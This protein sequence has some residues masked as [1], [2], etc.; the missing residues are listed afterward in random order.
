[1]IPLPLL[2]V[3]VPMAIFA[4]VGFIGYQTGLAQMKKNWDA[5]KQRIELAQAREYLR[6]SEA[7]YG[8][9][10]R[11][12]TREKQAQ[13]SIAAARA[14]AA[15]VRDAARALVDDAESRSEALRE[16][17]ASL[18]GLVGQCALVVEGGV[19]RVEALGPKLEALQS[20][21]RDVLVK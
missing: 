9:N 16:R 17:V 4:L 10:D 3:A 18:A 19:D 11:Y 6:A 2:K 7:N 5:D 20:R 14:D 1:M 8:I 15:S 13:T 21:E 12:T